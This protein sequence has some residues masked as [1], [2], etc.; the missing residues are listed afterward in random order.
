[1]SNTGTIIKHSTLKEKTVCLTLDVEQ[2]FG[3][4]LKSPRYEGIDRIKEFVLFI[5]EKDLPLTC[6]VQGSLFDTHTESIQHF[7][8][9]DTE[10]ELHSYSHPGP[11][12]MD[13]RLEIEK[14]MEAYYKFTGNY[15]AGYRSP[16]GAIQESDYSILTENHFQY[17]S[18]VFPTIRPGIFNNFSK[19][20]RPFR[21]TGT[22]MIEFPI[23]VL[24]EFIRVPIALSY[25]KLFGCCY[26]SIL[27][28]SRL[29][30]LII[31]DFHLHDLF[32]LKSADLLPLDEHS[33]MYRMIF[34]RIY[35]KNIDGL[36]LFDSFIQT[37]KRKKYR[38][39][40]LIDVYEDVQK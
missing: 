19:P 5:K 21:K 26:S 22:Q 37:L 30:D 3:E 35:R 34:N 39:R 32:P 7:K 16:L 31:F 29:P 6:F 15:P 10:F 9:I 18:S 11:S 36:S 33:L 38:F 13:S 27:K 17:D 12:T 20:N 1:M 25:I 24:S 28:A 2:D 4:L 40:K 8:E 14:G 23:T